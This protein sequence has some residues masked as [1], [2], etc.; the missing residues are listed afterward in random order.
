MK[1]IPLSQGLFALVDD[2][3]FEVLNQY[4]WSIL[5][6]KTKDRVGSFYAQSRID[7]HTHA[8]MHRFLLKPEKEQ[9]ID[10]ID[11]NGLNN[12]KENLRFLT[13]SENGHNIGRWTTNKSGYKGVH[14]SSRDKRWVAQIQVRNKRTR[15][16]Y[17]KSAEEAGNAY[18]EAEEMYFPGINK[19]SLHREGH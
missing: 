6:S 17:F 2:E 14:W 18:K 11:G 13:T 15:L 8:L 1:K 5:T 12:Q 3:D 10:H 4:K 16:G 19:R 7:R 9:Y